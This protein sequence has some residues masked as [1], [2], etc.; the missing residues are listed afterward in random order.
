MGI[1]ATIVIVLIVGLL[2]RFFIPVR[3]PMSSEP[4]NWRQ[5]SPRIDRTGSTDPGS[6]YAS[7]PNTRTQLSGKTRLPYDSG[8]LPL[9]LSDE[10]LGRMDTL[11]RDAIDERLRILEGVQVTV[12]NCIVDLLRVKSVLPR[13]HPQPSKVDQASES[14]PSTDADI[15]ATPSTGKG[16]E[17]DTTEVGGDAQID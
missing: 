3:D 13:S 17:K 12:S 15:A 6:P 9:S 7:R 4:F 8:T 1:I 2:A 5:H 14:T 10:Q 16:K 11:T